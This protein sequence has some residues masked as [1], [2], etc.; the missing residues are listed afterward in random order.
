MTEILCITHKYPPMI[1]RMEQQSFELIKGLSNHYKTHII[2][3]KNGENKVLWF[4]SLKSKIQTTLKENPNIKLIHL[5][6]GS[7]GIACLWL[8]KQSNIP[9]IVTYHG[10]DITFPLDFF[11]QKLIPKLSEFVG[12]IC[13]SQSTKNECLERGL[14]E[15][16]TFVVKNGVDSHIAD[17]PFDRGIIEKLRLNFGVD[18]TGKHILVILGRPVKRKGFSWFLKNV[19]PYLD[20]DICLLMIGTMKTESSFFEKVLQAMPNKFSHNVQLMLGSPSDTQSVEEQL[21]LQKNIFHLGSLPYED[22][23]QVLSI[24]DLFIMPNIRVEGDI[25]GFGLVALEASMR[26]TFVLASGIE[27]ITDA[28]IDRKNGY[29]LPN[30]NASAWIDKIHELLSK[31]EKLKIL[32]K[33]GKAYTRNNFSWNIMVDE[34]KT[35]FDKFILLSQEVDNRH[36]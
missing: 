26:G 25:E 22:L 28:V 32:S 11:Q 6:D 16:K 15:R 31:K 5:N 3:Y 4:G 36:S 12:A 1:G 19:M 9:V 18:V 2:A 29:L 23:L 35:I 14:S 13:V 10:L 17:I 34:Y 7:M 30:E 20:K 27:G 21:K 8:R 33:Q 24:A